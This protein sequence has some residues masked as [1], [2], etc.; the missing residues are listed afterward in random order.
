[1]GS[2]IIFQ[3]YRGFNPLENAL[4]S[5]VVGLHRHTK[6]ICFTNK[7]ASLKLGTSERSVTNVIN[8]FVEQGFVKTYFDGRRRFIYLQKEPEL[9]SVEDEMCETEEDSTGI[10]NTSTG[11]EDISSQ[12]GSN[13]NTELKDIQD[14]VENTSNNN[15]DNI[16]DNKI[17]DNIEDIKEYN[18]E[19]DISDEDKRFYNEN[20]IEIHYIMD[21]LQLSL[22]EAIVHHKE[23]LKSFNSV[24][25]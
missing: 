9:F 5:L 22:E 25:D 12:D 6:N 18:K 15:I 4:M 19:S 13:F 20:R 10:E 21:N 2:Y 3:T 14:R 7:Y 8:K 23:F 16:I 24:F 17:V 1:M 11:M